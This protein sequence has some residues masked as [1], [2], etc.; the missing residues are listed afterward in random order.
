[1]YNLVMQDEYGQK[2]ILATSEDINEL[3]DKA[4]DIVFE[5]N[6]ANA[7]TL[8]EQKREWE[9]CWV[10][11]F[12][13]DDEEVSVVYAGR[14]GVRNHLVYVVDNEDLCVEETDIENI[15]ATPRFYIGKIIKDFRNDIVEKVYAQDTKGQFVSDINDEELKRKGIMFIRKI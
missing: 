9:A 13:E 14:K 15:T 11:F 1:M 7:L 10:D 6:M 8:D 4:K 5:E 2:S 12:N 3:S